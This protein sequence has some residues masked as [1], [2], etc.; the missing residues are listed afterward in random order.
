MKGFIEIS[1]SEKIMVLGGKDSDIAKFMELLGYG[2][3]MIVKMIK[4]IRK[5]RNPQLAQQL[6][7]FYAM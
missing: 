4:D 1:A 7:R 3:G 5:G 6:A 2:I